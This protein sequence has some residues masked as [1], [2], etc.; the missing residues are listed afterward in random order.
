MFSNRFEFR[1][2][3]FCCS[4]AIL[5]LS[6]TVIPA[7]DL[8]GADVF[9]TKCVACHGPDGSGKTP[10]GEQ[11]K[12]LDLRSADVQKQTDAALTATIT[13]GKAPMPPF[14]KT[15]DAAQIGQVVA[16]VR[17]LAKGN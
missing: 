7:A 11:M 10:I 3:Q 5:F 2:V 6:G 4:I 16:Y 13:A 15:L 12:V 9:K 1:R 8:P 17:T 14:G